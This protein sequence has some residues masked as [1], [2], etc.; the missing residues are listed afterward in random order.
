MYERVALGEEGKS[1]L[2]KLAGFSLGFAPKWAEL[3]NATFHYAHNKLL[4]T[5]TV[6]S[7]IFSIRDKMSLSSSLIGMFIL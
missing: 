3:S 6:A 1:R 7:I 4:A 2:V 5:V